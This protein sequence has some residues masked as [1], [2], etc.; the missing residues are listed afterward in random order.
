MIVPES[1]EDQITSSNDD[2]ISIA[3]QP[4]D[5]SNESVTEKQSISENRLAPL[6]LVKLKSSI[7]KKREGDLTSI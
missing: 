5:Q 1:S 3:M 2:I 4:L 7:K 6:K